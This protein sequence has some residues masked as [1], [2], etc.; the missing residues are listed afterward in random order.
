VPQRADLY[1][2]AVAGATAAGH[3]ALNPP[4]FLVL[5][6][7]ETVGSFDDLFDLTNRAHKIYRKKEATTRPPLTSPFQVNVS[8]CA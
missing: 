6:Q 7:A 4:G 8:L 1:V 2:A 5:G 3:F